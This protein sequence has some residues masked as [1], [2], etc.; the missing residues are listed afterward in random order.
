M[1]YVPLT[2]ADRQQMLRTIGVPSFESLL[3]GIPPAVPRARLNLPAALSEPELAA[4]CADLAAADVTSK[5][6]LCFL[7]RKSVV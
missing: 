3:R 5:S 6:H 2:D 4:A 1:D 7:D